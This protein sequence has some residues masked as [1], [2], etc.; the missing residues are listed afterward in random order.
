MTDHRFFRGITVGL[1]YAPHFRTI[2]DVV[3][4][5]PAAARPDLFH[6]AQRRAEA[7]FG[8]RPDGYA[9][10]WFDLSPDAL[11]SLDE[12]HLPIFWTLTLGW[13][14]RSGD[15]QRSLH[16][17]ALAGQNDTRSGLLALVR[18]MNVNKNGIPENHG[19]LSFTCGPSRL[20]QPGPA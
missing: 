12:P 19:V 16:G 11:G 18:R 2:T 1:P 3:P 10:T 14:D 6:G 20:D 17:E 7:K 13:R 5:G 15:H 9:T 4:T 8:L